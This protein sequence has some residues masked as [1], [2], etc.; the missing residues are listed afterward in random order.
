MSDAEH[1]HR[2]EYWPFQAPV[3]AAS[4]TCVHVQNEG[5]SVLFV[6]HDSDGDWQFLCGADHEASEGLVVCLGCAV[7]AD[8]SLLALSDLP[9]GWCAF[10]DSV[11]AA[12]VR[13]VDSPAGADDA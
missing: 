11:A 10:R 13:E 9:D 5:R 2:F 12:W 6:M 1:D 3:Y 4:F 7:S 8:R